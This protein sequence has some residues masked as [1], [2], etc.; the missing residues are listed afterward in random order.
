MFIDHNTSFKSIMTEI[1][2]KKPSFGIGIQCLGTHPSN[3][4]YNYIN[5]Q[6]IYPMTDLIIKGTK[7]TPCVRFQANGE[8][9]LEGRAFNEDPK[10]FFQPLI[11]MCQSFSTETL[12]LE[13]RLD[14][15]NTSSSKMIIELIKTIDANTNIKIKDIKWFYEEDD[16]DILET[17][18][19]IEE[20]TL[21]TNF[22]FFEVTA[23]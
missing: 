15:L 17:G 16:E 3:K 8:F 7:D 22:Y 23:A 14:Y 13:V 20:T 11:K 2:N 6:N 19:I 21:S 9:F 4:E 18:Q 10:T 5:E 1:I 12:S